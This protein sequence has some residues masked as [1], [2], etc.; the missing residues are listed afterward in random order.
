MVEK[1]RVG[2]EKR[3]NK[4]RSEKCLEEERREDM[5]EVIAGGPS[6]AVTRLKRAPN[7]KI[8][9]VERCDDCKE[10]LTPP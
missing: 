3:S 6:L 2:K 8:F 1:E 9:G 4:G 7:G 5:S 10:Y